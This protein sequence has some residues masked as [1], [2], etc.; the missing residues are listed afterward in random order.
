MKIA[1]ARAAAELG[2]GEEEREEATQHRAAKSQASFEQG[3]VYR[4]TMREGSDALR[5][6]GAASREG[7][8]FVAMVVLLKS[9]GGASAVFHTPGESFNVQVEL[10]QGKDRKQSFRIVGP[11]RILSGTFDSNPSTFRGTVVDK[12]QPDKEVASFTLTHDAWRPPEAGQKKSDKGRQL[13]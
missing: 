11:E 2:T 12:S 4:G 9:P 3:E 1:I 7:D 13:P 8:T 6:E 10:M 5:L